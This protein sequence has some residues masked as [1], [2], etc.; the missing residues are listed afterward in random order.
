MADFFEMPKLGMDMTE[1]TIVKW[2][3]NPGETVQRGEPLAEIETDK[4]AVEVESPS[5]GVLLTRYYEEGACLPCGTILAAIGQDGEAAPENP[6]LRGDACTSS[7][8]QEEKVPKTASAVAEYANASSEAVTQQSSNELKLGAPRHRASPRARRLAEKNDVDLSLLSGTGPGGRI[9]AADV[10]GY[11]SKQ[12]G[13]QKPVTVRRHVE[14]VAPLNGIRKVTAKRM[15]QSTSQTAQANHRTDVNMSAAIDFREQVNGRWKESEIKIS[16]LDI[17][18][19][20]CAKALIEHPQANASLR[21]DGLH[22][23]NY[24]NVGIA[25]DTER[26]LVVPVLADADC[27]PLQEISKR[28]RELIEKAREGRLTPAEMSGGTF[29]ISN[30]GVYEIDSFTAIL[31]PPESCILAVGRIVN[32][33][34]PE[35]EK[36]V[37]RPMVTLSLTYDHQVLDGAPAARFL[38]RI[39][40]YLEHPIWLLI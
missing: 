2:L 25:V 35:G 37:V 8:G 13:N 27:L 9:V 28:S 1:G 38:C 33:V 24:A 6:Q 22:T 19:A 4:S 30:L 12:G 36:I 20:A 16:F 21:E 18:V 15:Y 34:V 29:T 32:R 40:E 5:T 17:L 14:F 3:K 26:G 31:N 39:K 7:P 10:S 23:F 11:L